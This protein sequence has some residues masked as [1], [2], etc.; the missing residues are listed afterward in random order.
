MKTIR[1]LQEEADKALDEMLAIKKQTHDEWGTPLGGVQTPEYNKAFA[2]Y[3]IAEY[4]LLQEMNRLEGISN[5]TLAKAIRY[6][7]RAKK[8]NISA[9]AQYEAIKTATFTLPKRRSKEGGKDAT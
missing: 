1:Q 9:F 7:Q 5:P 3:K 8:L 4:K 6:L 2:D